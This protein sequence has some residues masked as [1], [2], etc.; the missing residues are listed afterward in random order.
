M[1]MKTREKKTPSMHATHASAVHVTKKAKKG[2]LEQPCVPRCLASLAATPAS[3]RRCR[4][5]RSDPSLG[6]SAYEQQ[7]H[8]LQQSQQVESRSPG[9]VAMEALRQWRPAVKGA[10]SIAAADDST[11]G[12]R[13]ERA[14]MAALL[15]NISAGTV[16][17]YAS[18]SMPGIELEPWYGLQ[19]TAPPSQWV[20]DILLLGAATGALFSGPPPT[21]F[22]YTRTADKSNISTVGRQKLAR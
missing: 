9:N 15:V 18:V 13:H 20:A 12:G 5:P 16:L 3:E 7:Q 22:R 21:D 11:A 19:H 10:T 4:T 8:Q 6:A 2:A 14:M 17:G 1:I